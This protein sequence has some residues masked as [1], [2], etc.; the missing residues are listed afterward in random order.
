MDLKQG[1]SI[2]GALVGAAVLGVLG[3]LLPSL[4]FLWILLVVVGGVTIIGY[5]FAYFFVGQG[6]GEFF[7]GFLIGA[8]AAANAALGA[9]VYGILFG[10]I[11]GLLVGLA[12]GVLNLLAMFKVF[13][14]SGFFQGLLGWLNFL[15]PMSWLVTGLGLLFMALSGLGALILGWG[16][17]TPNPADNPFFKITDTAA[18]WKTGTFF[19]R[20]GWIANCNPLRGSAF[21]MGN[22]AFAKR[23]APSSM[24][25]EHEAGHTLNLAAFGSV[26]HFV[27]ALDENVFGSGSQAFAERLAESNNPGSA[28]SAIVLKMWT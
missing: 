14:N 22:F 17:E 15:L 12:L 7:R 4:G 18:D 28:S 6:G 19:L 26:F 3:Y 25:I 23:D 21:N 2:P 8:N 20:G 27:G 13:T 5:L 24:H 16:A 10:G 11:A 9:T 1:A